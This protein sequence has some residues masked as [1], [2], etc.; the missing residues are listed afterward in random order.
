MLLFLVSRILSAACFRSKPEIGDPVDGTSGFDGKAPR[1]EIAVGGH[2][3]VG[4][5][6]QAVNY[7]LE[8]SPDR[9][10][11]T[12]KVAEAVARFNPRAIGI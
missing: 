2:C 9:R 7:W 3:R 8:I 5:V 12:R 6:F 11:K 10:P 4:A 1:G